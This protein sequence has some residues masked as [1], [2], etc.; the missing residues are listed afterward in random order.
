M[1]WVTQ[2]GGVFW[3][4]LLIAPWTLGDFH[5]FQFNLWMVMVLALLGLHVLTGLGGMISIGHGAWLGCGAYVAAMTAVHLHWPLALSLLA[6]TLMG[7]ALGAL[8]AWVAGRLSGHLL[9]LATF[10]LAAAWPQVLKAPGLGAWTGGSQ[11]L[12]WL[13]FDT[14]SDRARLYTLGL[15]LL[16]AACMALERWAR[17]R[18]WGLALQALRDHPQALEALGVN[19]T[20]LKVCAFAIS[21]ALTSLAGG[22]GAAWVGFVSPDAYSAFLSITLLVGL[23][24]SGVGLLSGLW[25]GAA[26]VQ[27][28]PNWAGEWSQSMPWALQ[29]ACLLVVAY[30]AP[31]GWRHTQAAW[32]RRWL[33]KSKRKPAE[34]V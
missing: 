2:L 7:A 20:P 21:G 6:A 17:Q 28:V 5:L 15:V 33:T 19:L 24:V 25:L 14:A 22:L 10:A 12:T 18:H 3:A 27:F 29:G 1:R 11:G 13:A 8:M 23:A 16:L 30:L 9:A 26:F 34:E 4:A 31:Q 32:T